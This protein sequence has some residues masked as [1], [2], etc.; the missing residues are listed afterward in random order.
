MAFLEDKSRTLE[1]LEE[2]DLKH[3]SGGQASETASI[4]PQNMQGIL[5]EEII[6]IRLGDYLSLA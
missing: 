1:P 3:I 6:K 5:P 2:A 4:W